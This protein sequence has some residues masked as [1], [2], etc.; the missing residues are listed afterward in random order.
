MSPSHPYREI[1]FEDETLGAADE[2]ESTRYNAEFYCR[3]R[4]M[5]SIRPVA[6]RAGLRVEQMTQA[7][8]AGNPYA[9][10]LLGKLYRDGT[11]VIPDAEKAGLVSTVG[12]AGIKRRPVRLGQTAAHR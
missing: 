9:Q 8:Q 6:G 1:T 2:P 4:D 7:A 11:V 10:H 12:G 3:Y 5:I